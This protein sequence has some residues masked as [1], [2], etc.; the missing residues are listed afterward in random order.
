VIAPVH[1]RLAAV[2][3]GRTAAAPP[4]PQI[5]IWWFSDPSLAVSTAK[6][7]RA[8]LILPLRT[9]A[10]RTRKVAFTTASTETM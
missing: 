7:G 4:I 8:S 1:A 9:S 10:Q 2:A 3:T 6:D 5:R